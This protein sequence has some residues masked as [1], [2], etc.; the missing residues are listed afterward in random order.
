[1]A[2]YVYY[3]SLIVPQKEAPAMVNLVAFVTA[4]QN[5]REIGPPILNG[6]IY[7]YS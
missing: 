2:S 6:K 5:G 7:T 4:H 3:I 1:M